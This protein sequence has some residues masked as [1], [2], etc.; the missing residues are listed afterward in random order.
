MTRC[1]H[2]ARTDPT[3]WNELKFIAQCWINLK[4]EHR[5]QE[6]E[7]KED[8]KVRIYL[9]RAL[10]PAS[11]FVVFCCSGMILSIDQNIRY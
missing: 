2:T 11:S 1:C 8:C 4:T 7:N 3:V 6:V 5:A 10:N 9:Q